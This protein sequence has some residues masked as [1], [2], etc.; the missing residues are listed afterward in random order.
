[1]KRCTHCRVEFPATTEFFYPVYPSRSTL[2]S[3][4]KT[5]SLT[6]NA[7]YRKS[8]WPRHLVVAAAQRLRRR[9]LRNLVQRL[10]R[11][12]NR[13]RI[14][15]YNARYFPV[16][17]ARRRGAPG[18]FSPAQWEALLDEWSHTCAYCGMSGSTPLSP[19]HRTPLV[20]GGTNDIANI[21]PACRPCNHQKNRKTEQEYR[22]YR[23]RLTEV[24]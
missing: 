19:D 8:N 16:H 11:E 12:K 21:L 7:T 20:R 14:R 24:A 4:C 13:E 17:N 22:A 9:D 3:W 1:M 15:E 5:C 10:W 2:A 18:A 6:V 23:L